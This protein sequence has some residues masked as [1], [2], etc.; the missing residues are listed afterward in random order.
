[1]E[2]Y[3]AQ[4]S[5]DFAEIVGTAG[6][7]IPLSNAWRAATE[8]ATREPAAL[9]SAIRLLGEAG[10][11]LSVSQDDARKF[12]ARA[13][14]LLQAESDSRDRVTD[15]AAD[16]ARSRLAPWQVKRVM[17]FIDANLSAKLGA[18]DLAELVRL[19]TSHFARAFRSTV[20]KSPYAY[21]LHRRIERAK[22]MMLE[23]DSPLVQIALDCGLADQ[24]HFTKLFTRIVGISPAAWRRAHVPRP[25]GHMLQRLSVRQSAAFASSPACHGER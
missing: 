1:M 17:R 21:L 15:E 8:R 10:R 4:S 11:V 19:S 23:T 5:T 18:Q 13:T 25:I 24:A 2:M 3:D 6:V 14:A 20:G 12:I 16:A 9:R 7:E 22:E